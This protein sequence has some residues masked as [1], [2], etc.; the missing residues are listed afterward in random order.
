MR[1]YLL[2]SLRCDRP[3][4]AQNAVEIAELRECL[5]Q[6][7]RRLPPRERDALE[8]KARLTEETCRSV[9]RR[10]G[11]SP[12]SACNWAACAIKK[13]RPKLEAHR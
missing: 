5:D 9:A 7:L 10:Y 13:L 4:E 8:A 11:A 12:Q 1:L 6:Q 2:E 3:R